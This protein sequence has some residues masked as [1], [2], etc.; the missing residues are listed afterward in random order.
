[1][2]VIAPRGFRLQFGSGVERTNRI[3]AAW[4]GQVG[5]PG[6]ARDRLGFAGIVEGNGQIVFAVQ[7]QKRLV[8]VAYSKVLQHR[9]RARLNSRIIFGLCE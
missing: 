2:D 7:D 5:R 9:A 3:L 4:P 8:P 6:H 1:M